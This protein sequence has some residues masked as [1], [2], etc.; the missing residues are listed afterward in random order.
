MGNY[1]RKGMEVGIEGSENYDYLVSGGLSEAVGE[2]YY[3]G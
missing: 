3:L 2:R 1:Q